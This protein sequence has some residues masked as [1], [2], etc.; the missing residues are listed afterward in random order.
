MLSRLEH[1]QSDIN[2]AIVG[3]GFVGTSLFYQ[4]SI[5]PGIR[6]VAVADIEPTKAIACLESLKRDYRIVDNLTAMHEATRQGLVAVSEHGDLVARCRSADV[7]IESSSAIGP[8][9]Q[10]AITALEHRKHVVMMNAEADLI[11]GPYLAY[12]ARECGVVYTSCD[13]D[14]HGVIRHLIND[15]RLWGLR[16]VMAGNIK[17]FLDRHAN[18][19]TIVPEAD[20]RHLTYRMAT[21]FTDGTKLCIEMALLANALGLSTHVPGMH[22]PRACD[23]RDVF[24]LF[25]FDA[26]RETGEPVVD[27][28][29][30]AEPDGGVFSVGYC[31]DGFQQRMLS[32]YKMGDGPYYLFYRP[33][34]LCHIEAMN[35]VAEAFL[36]QRSLLQ[37]NFGF[38]TN[39]YAYAKSDLR[40]GERL[41]GIGGYTCYGLIENCAENEEQGGLPICLAGDVTLKRAVA[42]DKKILMSDI[43][44]KASRFDFNLYFKAAGIAPYQPDPGNHAGP[45]CEQ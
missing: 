21:A 19:T 5:T 15:L 13:G 37:P 28:V 2:V 30:G 33:Y 9:G 4:C 36:D 25:D 6:C 10:V 3:T 44:Y 39:V 1:L 24:D 34:H 29:L 20:E 23:V 11:F 14:Q 22:G 8:A 45:G 18:P 43:T 35:T 31:D 41:D 17:G 42:K 16:L 12:L 40:E 7:L 26:L 32:Y 27:Y 38:R